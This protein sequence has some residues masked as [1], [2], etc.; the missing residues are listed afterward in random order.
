MPLFTKSKLMAIKDKFE[1]MMYLGK[2]QRF[3]F[4]PLKI[5]RDY[6]GYK[7]NKPGVS[8]NTTNKNGKFFISEVNKRV[9]QKINE[10]A[11]V[12][13][14]AKGKKPL[15][16]LD[17]SVHGQIKMKRNLNTNLINTVIRYANYNNVKALHNTGTGGMYLKTVF[18]KQKNYKSALKLMDILWTKDHS[19]HP[20]YLNGQNNHENGNRYHVAIGLSLGYKPED[21]LFF[22]NKD[23]PKNK[24]ADGS[25]IKTVSDILKKMN[26]TLEDLQKHTP[27]VVLDKIPYLGSTRYIPP[28]GSIFPSNIK[29]S[30]RTTNKIE[31][32]KRSPKTTAIQREARLREVRKLFGTKANSVKRSPNSTLPKKTNSVKR[33]PNSTLVKTTNSVKRSPNSTLAK[34]T[35][36]VK[37]SPNTT[38]AKT[39]NSVKRSPNTTL[40][41]I[42]V[43]F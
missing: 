11:D 16:A 9:E 39:T 24:Q 23:K 4:D 25:I 14:V 13:C 8:K 12:Y 32:I 19:S 31:G 35:N 20:L 36:S 5:Y 21:I 29:I 42:A 2:K 22:L 30:Q 34:T 15:A 40:A 17:Y 28:P 38:L 18:F 1:K 6:K 26:V 7:C 10:F 41:N 33:S 27:I 3:L 37:R 43:Q